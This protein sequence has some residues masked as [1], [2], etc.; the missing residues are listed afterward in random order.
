[1]VVMDAYKENNEVGNELL[2]IKIYKIDMNRG[3]GVN[4]ESISGFGTGL[5]KREYRSSE[6]L[7]H[8]HTY[9]EIIFF[10]EGSAEVQINNRYFNVNK[11]QV[12]LINSLD[13]HSVKG[14]CNHIAM[15]ID[16]KSMPNIKM[17][18]TSIFPEKSEDKLIGKDNCEDWIKNIIIEDIQ[19]IL[20]MYQN[21]TA[22][23]YFKILGRIY[24][25]L[26]SIWL[27]T[28]K[29]QS[30]HEIKSD[31]KNE[32]LQKLELI[33]NY[34]D[35]NY[36]E[37]ISLNQISKILNFSP[38]YFC[39]FFKN[40]MG[41]SFFEYLNYYRC[42]RAEILLNT[43]E[44]SITEIA[45]E[46]GFNSVSYFDKTYKKYKGYEPSEERCGTKNE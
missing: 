6:T 1:V 36:H 33:F 8:W 20:D 42:S 24:D 37:T 22:G 38:N 4:V 30:N 2:P 15:L 41:R 28:S 23:Y 13:I 7:P 9:L 17:I 19:F 34:L 26:G 14:K 29:K 10:T 35:K 46:V 40:N 25:M 39:R 12:L 16:I 3:I 21:K 18:K 44:K 45:L 5:I 43:S 27:Y 11:G 32:N 31:I